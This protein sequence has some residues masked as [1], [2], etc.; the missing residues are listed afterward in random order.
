VNAKL[1]FN[2]LVRARS[3]CECRDRDFCLFAFLKSLTR[4]SY[5]PALSLP[6]MAEPTGD[7]PTSGFFRLP[8]ELRDEVYDIAFVGHHIT[9]Y[10]QKS[11]PKKGNSL[12]GL[13]M[14][15]KQIREEAQPRFFGA[16]IFQISI[17]GAFTSSCKRYKNIAR[18]PD[19]FVK[20]IKRV[21]LRV[22]LDSTDILVRDTSYSL[23]GNDERLRRILCCYFPENFEATVK[24]NK[25][26][27][28]CFALKKMGMFL[29]PGV[30]KVE[31]IATA[32]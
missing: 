19:D 28:L 10:D 8:R 20:Y 22:R 14:D 7:Q 32:L 24:V 5:W 18:V 1:R 26:N 16:A 13:L 12:Q 25:E 30:L 23:A 21:Q 6:A 31:L 11:F 29:N 15:K 9:L 4:D 3:L 2:W 27:Q 17:T